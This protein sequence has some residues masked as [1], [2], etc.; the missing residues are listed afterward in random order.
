MLALARTP[1]PQNLQIGRC[2]SFSITL[3]FSVGL[4]GKVLPHAALG[5]LLFHHKQSIYFLGHLF[6]HSRTRGIDDATRMRDIT[7]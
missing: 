2:C 7:H 3:P 4:E 6:V 1:L 5:V